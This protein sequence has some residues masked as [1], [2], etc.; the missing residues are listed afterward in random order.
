[1]TFACSKT[2][3]ADLFRGPPSHPGRPRVNSSATSHDLLGELGTHLPGGLATS[4]AR[5]VTPCPRPS[6]LA[7]EVEPLPAEDGRPPALGRA[8]SCARTRLHRARPGDLAPRPRHIVPR[9]EEMAHVA[10]ARRTGGRTNSR[11]TW[12]HPRR[13]LA[14]AHGWSGHLA[15]KVGPRQ[16]EGGATSRARSRHIAR[17][18]AAHPARGGSACARG[19]GAS[20][21]SRRTSPVRRP[22]LARE[23]VRPRGEMPRPSACG[24]LTS[25]ARTCHVGVEDAS[26]RI[27]DV[28]PRGRHEDTSRGRTSRLAPRWPRLVPK[29][30]SPR[31]GHGPASTRDG[32]ASRR[33]PG[34]L[35]ND[36]ALP[37]AGDGPTPRGRWSYLPRDMDGGPR[38]AWRA[39][40]GSGEGSTSCAL[41]GDVVPCE[42]RL[43]RDDPVRGVGQ[44]RVP[45]NLGT[46]PVLTA[47][48]YTKVETETRVELVHS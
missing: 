9:P 38:R 41:A 39:L 8:S 33:S 4:G 25:H 1:M 47:N 18:V 6:Y 31:R 40:D 32:A 16:P 3:P 14:T 21:A 22:Y 34:R 15:Q 26:P 28:R 13:R 24:D 30:V 23:V 19:H 10:E 45:A 42:A 27:E 2:S 17:E 35:S 36:M 43:A 20:R 5:S 29:D 7:C 44:A 46:T 37:H 11:A 12:G 48:I